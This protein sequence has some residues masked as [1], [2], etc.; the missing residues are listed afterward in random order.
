[1]AVKSMS[2]PRAAYIHVPFC[3]HHCGYCNFTV[4]AGRDELQDAYLDALETELASLESPRPVDTLY[5]GGGTPTHLN[6]QRL[7]RLMKQLTHWFPLNEGGEWSIEA[8]PYRLSRDKLLMLAE[9]GV[10]R[11][12]LGVQSFNSRNLELLERETSIRTISCLVMKR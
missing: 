11:V 8:N 2:S 7:S 9:Y 3:R 1:M 10:N 4:V 12:S 5:V 6:L